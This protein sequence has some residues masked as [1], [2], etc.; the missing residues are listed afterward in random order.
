MTPQ[1]FI[2][3]SRQGVALVIVLAMLVLLS[4]LIVAFF[5]SV[6]TERNATKADSNVANARAI[7]DATVNM[8]VAQIREATTRYTNTATWASQPGAIRTF[9]G[10]E[11]SRTPY[12]KNA[13]QYPYT[14]GTSDY[15]YKLYSADDMRVPAG[16]YKIGGDGLKADVAPI[17][18]WLKDP[19]EPVEGYVDLNEPFVSRYPD[20]KQESGYAYEPRYPILDP[21]ARA[22]ANEKDNANVFGIVEGFDAAPIINPSDDRRT[23]LNAQIPLLPMPVKWLYVLKDGTIGPI[24]HATED[25]PVVGRT[26]FWADDESTKLNI[27]TSTEGTFWDTPSVSC[28]QESGNVDGA[29]GAL[30]SGIDSLALGASQPITGNTS[31]TLATR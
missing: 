1:K 11:G 8:V 15:V 7:S 12:E 20:S 3:K 14:P 10:S 13:F 27:N 19:L 26:A 24:T 4:G 28:A 5:N 9:S 17:E 25:N 18:T 29:G 30:S 2:A 16:E 23:A 31:G 22:D 21:R 6:R